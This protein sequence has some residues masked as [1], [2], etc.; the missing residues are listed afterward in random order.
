MNR[1]A[2]LFHRFGP[3]HWARLNAAGTLSCTLGLELSAET[4][5]YGWQKVGGESTFRR[6]TLFPES[7]GRLAPTQ[8]L[9][10]RLHA[11]LDEY[12]PAA[13][14]IPGWSDKGAL[15][16]LSWCLKK[17][18]PAIVMSES[19]ASDETRQ[20]PKEAIKR[21]VVGLCATALTGGTTQANYLATLG[22][23][24]PHIFTGYDVVDNDYFSRESEVARRNADELRARLNLPEKYFLASN[25]FIVKKN[26]HRLLEAYSGYRQLAGPGGWKL[27]LLGDGPLK[28][29]LLAQVEQLGLG[30]DV[31]LR[32]FKQYDELPAYY[33][34]AGAF[35]HASTTEQWGLV[36]NEAMA[37]GLPVLIS[38][39]CGC[40]IDLVV[41]GRN[42]FTFNPFH[43]QALIQLLLDLAGKKFDLKAMGEA[44]REIVARWSPKTFAANLLRA[45]ETALQLPARKM[46]FLN[47]AVLQAL[48]RRQ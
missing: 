32:G 33:G 46:S 36:V 31:L 29:Q 7:D 27:V 37:C 8:E 2:V 18:K 45:T 9:A 28:P 44:S 23:P 1:I 39:R 15:A 4:S 12:Q 35:V 6:V 11:T 5:E 17:G 41:S 24:R 48:L 30:S 20:W 19:Q 14:A 22:M 25:R 40:A 3:Y 42:G 34:L 26:L 10:R 21:R 16:A 13:V 43:V 38:E 47:Q